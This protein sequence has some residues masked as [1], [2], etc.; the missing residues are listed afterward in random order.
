MLQDVRGN[1]QVPLSESAGPVHFTLCD[2][3]PFMVSAQGASTLD[4]PL[5]QSLT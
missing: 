2:V 3:K 5:P 1:L 4:E